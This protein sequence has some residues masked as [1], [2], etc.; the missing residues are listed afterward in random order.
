MD[1]TQDPWEMTRQEL[2]SLLAT[3]RTMDP[4]EMSREEL[5][6]YNSA[7]SAYDATMHLYL[8]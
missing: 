7:M 1:T 4:N 2:E 6:Y 8:G 5:A 3:L